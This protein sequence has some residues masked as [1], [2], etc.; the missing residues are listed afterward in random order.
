MPR[1]AAAVSWEKARVARQQLKHRPRPLPER[2]GVLRQPQAARRMD[3]PVAADPRLADPGGTSV[4]PE[5]WP[6][7]QLRWQRLRSHDPAQ[8]RSGRSSMHGHPQPG[9][10]APARIAG[11]RSS[12]PA[13]SDHAELAATLQSRVHDLPPR[14]PRHGKSRTLDGAAERRRGPSWPPCSGSPG[15][16]ES[17]PRIRP[18]RRSPRRATARGP[19]RRRRRSHRRRARGRKEYPGPERR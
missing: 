9:S 7:S 19:G 18:R 16:A 14:A 8:W 4:T 2:L 5:E 10:R 17:D 1:R 12:Q 6:T 13:P 3:Q 11:H 15:S